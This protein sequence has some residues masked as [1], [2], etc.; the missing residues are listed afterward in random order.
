MLDN[1]KE[2]AS[3]VFNESSIYEQMA[4]IN[5]NTVCDDQHKFGQ[6]NE[7]GM[8]ETITNE[9]TRQVLQQEFLI[10][11][12]LDTYDELDQLHDEQEAEIKAYKAEIRMLKKEINERGKKR[13]TKP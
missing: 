8:I 5:K 10:N 3:L 1:K 12:I 13:E 11:N 9:V 6:V 4:A 7:I 2:K